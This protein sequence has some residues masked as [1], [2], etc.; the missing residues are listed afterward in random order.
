VSIFIRQTKNSKPPYKAFVF[1]KLR[2]FYYFLNSSVENDYN[3]NYNV[4]IET[5]Q[6]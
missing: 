3:L 1:N 2:N 6:Q 5:F 4:L